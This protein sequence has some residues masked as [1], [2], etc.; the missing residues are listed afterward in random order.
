MIVIEKVYN[1]RALNEILSCEHF[2]SDIVYDVK[3]TAKPLKREEI[4][5][6]LTEQERAMTRQE[7]EKMLL[8]RLEG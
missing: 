3:I 2:R 8:E 6:T 5:H 7:Y 4:V 1:G